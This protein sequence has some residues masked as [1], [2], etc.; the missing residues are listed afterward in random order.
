MLTLR[1]LQKLISQSRRNVT[2][3]YGEDITD[4]LQM[5]SEH[6]AAALM[7]RDTEAVG[8]K[9]GIQRGQLVLTC[10]CGCCTASVSTRLSSV[11]DSLTRK[12]G[13]DQE[14]TAVLN[15]LRREERERRRQ[16]REAA[17]AANQAAAA[18]EAA[19]EAESQRRSSRPS[20]PPTTKQQ[21]EVAANEAA[22]AARSEAAQKAK[23]LKEEIRKI[24]STSKTQDTARAVRAKK[25]E[26]KRLRRK[27]S[28]NEA[29]DSEPS[30]TARRQIAG[31]TARLQAVSPSLRT[32][33][34]Q[35]INR[36]VG[37][38]GAMGGALGPTPILSARKL[39]KRMLVRRPLANALKEDTVTGRPV[40]LFLPDIS[41][42]CASTSQDAC[43]LAN[44]A[45]Y[46]GVPGS[47]VLVFPH[48]NGCVEPDVGY[49]PWFNGKP[50]AL[51]LEEQTRL[52]DDLIAG[53][54][55]YRVRVV[56]ALGDH[57]AVEMYQ[58]MTALRSITRLVWLHND[59]LTND[60]KQPVLVNSGLLPEWHPEQLK[61][62]SMVGGC[63]NRGFMLA[64][65]DLALR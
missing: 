43:D 25:G 13:A 19:E 38:S 65:F 54:S 56:V 21:Q 35:L 53:K 58:G 50:M 57:D 18:A 34:A 15:A 33:M 23:A 7:F 24:N 16:R 2:T 10:S 30:R 39:V 49:T 52:F 11:V 32:K 64:G 9:T 47:D 45:G 31:A 63:T 62:L 6:F 28:F 27:A 1:Q 5:L 37:Q 12:Y 4:V 59:R 41:P 46:S 20:A 51:S 14:V 17:R 36:L 26:L 40:T 8:G 42:S 48:S 29:N 3:T 61:K 44:A 55:R 60:H 22:R